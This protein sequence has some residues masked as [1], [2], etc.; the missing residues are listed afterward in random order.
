MEPPF[1]TVEQEIT[2]RER[3]INNHAVDLEAAAAATKTVLRLFMTTSASV[4][5]MYWQ[6]DLGLLSF[7][8]KQ[9]T[10]TVSLPGLPPLG[11]CDLPSFLAEPASQ[12][13]YLEAIME[14]FHSLNEDDWV[15]CNS[16]EDLEIELV[17]SMRGKWP[18]V[19]VGPMVPS[20]YLDQQIDGDRSYGA[21]LWKPKSS[22]CFAWLDT[23]PPLSVIYV[24]FGSMGNISAEQVEEIA[25]GLK[26]SN[27]PFLWV[28]KES[29]NKLPTEFLNSVGESGI[30]VSW[31]DQLEVLAHQAVGCF[32]THCGW[33]STLE[34]LALGVP[35]VCVTQRSDQ[36]MN[37]KF[38]EDV[39]KVGVRSEKDEVGI[40]KREELDR[41][42]REVM[43]GEKGGE[44]KRNANKWRELA[45]SAV[46]AGGTSDMNINE[47]V[48][49][50]LEGKKG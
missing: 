2:P 25:W 28:V 3:P 39:W 19:T 27:R 17:K 24:S 15:F 22:Q 7:P 26:A 30:V 40:V 10:E 31:C 35:M 21:S 32:V 41:C 5:S 6:I 37:A 8:L 20:A 4:C 43:D 29:E 16:F 42:I 18:L 13:A 47:F 34:G 48:V 36:P 46:I 9:Q 23:K 50:L 38:V 1:S 44:I 33:N 49:K 12:T 14:K 45:K 11:L